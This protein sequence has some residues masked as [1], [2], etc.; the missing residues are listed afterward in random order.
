MT[1]IQFGLHLVCKTA[2]I[3]ILILD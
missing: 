3:G 2:V 1:S